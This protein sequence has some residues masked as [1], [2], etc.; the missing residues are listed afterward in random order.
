VGWVNWQGGGCESGAD[1]GCGIEIRERK[2]R[3][4]CGQS[5]NACV[6][7]RGGEK[8]SSKHAR[9]LDGKMESK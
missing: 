6:S 9:G 1:C 3:I 5:L 4:M 8:G 7:V 2:K